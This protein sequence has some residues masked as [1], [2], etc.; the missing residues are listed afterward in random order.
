M[1]QF[2]FLQKYFQKSL[3]YADKNS[4]EGHKQNHHSS[5][6]TSTRFRTNLF[7]LECRNIS[8]NFGDASA[9]NA[10]HLNATSEATTTTNDHFLNFAIIYKNSIERKRRGQLNYDFLK[11]HNSGNLC[12]TK[13]GTCN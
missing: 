3:Q 11:L 9:T 13:S 8:I 12:T 4:L 7:G 10:C 6:V 5:Q 2:I 1:H